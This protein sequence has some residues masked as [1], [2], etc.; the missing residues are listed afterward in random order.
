MPVV[1][2]DWGDT[3]ILHTSGEIEVLAAERAGLVVGQQPA[4]VCH[5]PATARRMGL[6]KLAFADVL[7][8]F[9]FVRPAQFCVPTPDG[10][11]VATGQKRPLSLEDRPTAL[12]RAATILLGELVALPEQEA[13]ALRPLAVTM[14]RARWSWGPSVAVALDGIE[15]AGAGAVS[16]LRIWTR[17]PVWQDRAPPAP[18]G[19]IPISAEETEVRLREL[20]GHGAEDRVSQI[21]YARAIAGAFAPRDT[22]EAPRVVLAEAGTGIGKTLGYIAPASLWAEKNEGAV[23]ISTFTRNLQRQLNDE[24]SKLVPDADDKR[25]RIVIR[26]GREN[27]F[28]VLNFEDAVNRASTQPAEAIRLGLMARWALNTIAGDMIGGDLPGWLPEIL[29][30]DRVLDLADRRGECIYGACPHYQK[31]FIERTVRRARYADIVVSNHALVMMQAALGGLDDATRPTR[32]VFDE[33]HHIFEAADSAF[34]AHLSGWDTAE[35]RRWLLGAEDRGKSR[36]RGLKKRAEELI[37]AGS[38]DAGQLDEAVDQVVAAAHVL[39]GIGWRNRLKDGQPQGPTEKFLAA[40]RRQVLSR[41]DTDSPYS[42]EADTSYPIEGLLDAATDLSTALRALDN[43]LRRLLSGLK[44]KLDRDAAE[45]DSATRMRIESLLRSL[46]RRGL[47]Q[48]TAWRDM[49][50]ALTNATPAE[51]I[52]WFS[53]ER[54]NGRDVDIGLNR[55]WLDPTLPFAH[56]IADQAQGIALTSAT[57]LDGSGDAA[58]DWNSCDARAGITH[59]NTNPERVTLP[60]PFDYA[61]DTRVIV[62]TDVRKDDLRQVAAAYRELFLAAGG[63]G[64]GLFT[65]ITRLKD[66]H[67]RIAAALAHERIALY[68]QHV[69]EMDTSTLVDIFR[70]EENACLLGTDALREGVD[71]PG[72]SLRIVV[73][74]RVPW[75]RPDIL[76]KARRALFGK[77]TYDDAITRLRLK[78][79]FGRLIR[80]AGDRGVFVLLDPMMPSRLKG[81]FPADTPFE[82]VGLAEAVSHVRTFIHH[83]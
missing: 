77:R 81:A 6:T 82:R 62:V 65:A 42:L 32:Y 3:A 70:A 47:I 33:G 22:P 5:A 27:Y 50:S 66:V 34:A 56:A 59:M 45:L 64:L 23:W 30:S 19:S 83:G 28:C 69:D 49:L 29:G 73:F 15:G 58:A 55:H 24:L 10:L 20:L 63:G 7:E 43:P 80:R 46:E 52:D 31:C 41:V 16:G 67:S 35:L 72:R 79:A 17:L 76:H 9:A 57:L 8:L 36:S 78:Q 2:A 18:P 61:G 12:A 4:M 37:A 60:S 39:P 14:Y 68:A 51:F 13:S 21:T 71:V 75:P 38:G 25:R 26:K 40:I 48:L 1:V 11:A 54:D 44:G 53:I 74:D